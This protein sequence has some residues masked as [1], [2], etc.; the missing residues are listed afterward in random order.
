MTQCI[1]GNAQPVCGKRA[2]PTALVLRWTYAPWD[3]SPAVLSLCHYAT[4]E[5]VLAG[6]LAQICEWLRAEGYRHVSGSN[7]LWVKAERSALHAKLTRCYAA[8][9]RML[10]AARCNELP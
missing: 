6:D 10:G 8:L 3:G 9:R 2:Y 4:N 5:L 7:G 1:G